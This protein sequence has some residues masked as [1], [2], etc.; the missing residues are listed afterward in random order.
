[1]ILVS[2]A[3]VSAFAP[4]ASAYESEPPAILAY[5]GWA[6]GEL[7]TWTP[8]PAPGATYHVKFG[9]SQSEMI[10]IAKTAS[11]FY[12]VVRDTT[13]ETVYYGVSTIVDGIESDTKIIETGSSASCVYVGM[14]GKIQLRPYN[15]IP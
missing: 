6:G 3:V 13:W 15:C 14:S 4:T 5:T 9:P 2:L 8:V 7:L 12:N 11:P 10:V 1:M